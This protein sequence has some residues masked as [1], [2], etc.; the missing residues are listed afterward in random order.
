VLIADPA[1]KDT[2]PGSVSW[3]YITD[4]VKE[5]RIVDI[6]E[7]RISRANNPRPVGSSKP[8]KGTRTPFSR[9]DD[10][11]LVN[12]IRQHTHHGGNKIY[13]D[14]EEK[15]PSLVPNSSDM[16]KLTDIC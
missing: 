10:E 11:L 9:E 5:G 4:S 1:R 13:Q 14:L 2:P 16:G 12:W 15:V 8:S 3:K 6:D 7:Y